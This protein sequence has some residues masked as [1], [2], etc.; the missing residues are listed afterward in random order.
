MPDISQKDTRCYWIVIC[1]GQGEPELRTL[2]GSF[3]HNWEI[4][5]LPT[6]AGL[7]LV[8]IPCPK[9]LYEAAEFALQHGGIDQS[10]N[11]IN[12]LSSVIGGALL[13]EPQSEDQ[14]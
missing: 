3:I 9:Q 6:F 11:L 1:K 5:K 2:Q 4:E 7:P 10:L 8:I 13:N 12:W 14:A